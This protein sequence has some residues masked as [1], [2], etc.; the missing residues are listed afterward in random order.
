MN[1]II[2]NVI[3]E[4][5]DQYL[6]A[7]ESK[8]PW[9][10]GFSGGKDSTVMLQLV[11]KALERVKKLNGV[12]N[13]NVIIV[14][15][16]TMVENPVIS[17]YVQRVLN[18]I[19]K[20]ALKQSMPIQVVQTIPRL[21]DSFWVNLIGKGY[22]APNNAF[23]WCTER[24]KIRPTTRHLLE[25]IDEFGEAVILIGTRYSESTQRAKIMRKHDIKGS[26]LTKHPRLSNT[27]MYAPIRNLLLEE[28]WFVLKTME[29]PWGSDNYELFQI[30]SDASADDYECPT[31]ITSDHHKSCGQSRFGCWVCTVVKKDKSMKSLID[32]GLTW[33]SPLLKVRNELVEERNLIEN[34]LP[35]RRN[36]S[37]A[38]EHM[39][40][41]KPSYRASV[42]R[43][44]LLAQQEIQRDKPH[45]KLITNQEL[46]AIQTLWHRDLIF[47]HNVSSIYEEIFNLNVKMKSKNDKKDKEI[48]LLKKS[49]NNNEQDFELIRD[50]LSIQKRKSLLI[51]KRGLKDE[52]EKRIEQS[53]KSENK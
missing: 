6:Y 7:D 26:R 34:R 9:I 8:R 22:P 13:R 20:T 45:L 11:W 12:A 46:V 41:Y 10:I 28:V 27:Q 3:N 24:L 37:I 52:I 53:I 44:V 51:H 18:D 14:C 29:S 19:R 5:V 49:F 36:G 4:I 23:R 21:Q 33:L 15:N 30:Y 39:G 40:T 42:L 2:K 43:K 47:E 38:K 31:M 48:A 32:N 25:N 1:S 17:E 35:T 16:D 50:L